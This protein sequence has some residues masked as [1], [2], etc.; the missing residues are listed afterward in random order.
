MDAVEDIKSRLDIADAIQEYLPLKPAGTGSFKGLCPFHQEKSPS[1]FAN[2]PRQ[3]WHCFGCNEGGDVISF[4]MRMEGMDFREALEF[5]AQKTGVTLPSYDPEKQTLKRRLLEIN[6]LAARWFQ[7]TLR[8]DPRAEEAGKYLVSRGV[9]DLTADLWRIG[10][11][12]D[13]WDGLTNALKANGATDDELMQAGLA[14][15]SDRRS[16]VYDRFRDRVMFPISDVHGRIVGFTGRI[17]ANRKEA[18]YVNTP[19]TYLYK[20]SAVL[21]GL[22]KAKGEI[23]RQNLAIIVEGN[24]DALSSHQFGVTNVVASSGTALTEDQLL[25]LKR[26]TDTLAIAFDGDKAGDAATLRGLDVA[27][28]LDFNIRVISIPPEAGKDPDDIVRKDVSIWID[29]IAK[30]KPII[31]WLYSRAFAANDI[32]RPEGKKEIARALL[33]EFRRINDPVERDAWITKLGDDLEVSTDALRSAMKRSSI[34]TTGQ[35]RQTSDRTQ[36]QPSEAR[37]KNDK[38]RIALLEERMEAILYLKPQFKSRA[39]ELLGRH[40]LKNEHAPETLDLL[41]VIADREFSDQS[42]A[43]IERE[44]G[45]T[46][47]QIRQIKLSEERQA[48][49]REMRDA[50]RRKDDAKITELILRLRDL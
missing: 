5:L 14:A 3:S 26:Y 38:S 2:R 6:D 13:S 42:D 23:K 15:K 45:D 32:S 1:F 35:T 50:E 37:E 18:K 27:R 12:P 30:A 49:E 41:A 46:A 44:L 47:A 39:E 33:T 11:A 24:L 48:I 7:A 8:N 22:D 21:Y 40:A 36:Q 29:I 34:D 20:K 4:V 17:L 43:T 25:S 19:E 28:R 31:D 16:G 9:D 10:Y